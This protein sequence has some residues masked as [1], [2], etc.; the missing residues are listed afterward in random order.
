MVLAAMTWQDVANAPRDAVALIPTGA[1][2]QHGPFLPLMTDS[3]LVTAVAEEAERRLPGRVLLTPTLWLGASESHL[4]FA[5]TLSASFAGYGAALGAVVESLLAHGFHRY[6]VLNGHGGNTAPNAVALRELKARHPE[7][8]FGTAAYPEFGAAVIARTLAGPAKTMLHACEAETSL[9]LH[10]APDLV[11]M[12][13]VR[14]DGLYPD[15]PVVGMVHGF[16]EVS[17]EGP[18]GY[19]S[20]ATA[21]KGRA[22]FEACVEGLVKNLEW[23]ADGYVLNAKPRG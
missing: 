2:E 14:D 21:E 11:R 20:L 22:I 1:L 10:V 3:I 18:L 8:T 4:P 7:A 15:P 6:F 13:R 19:A 12:D 5:G 23:L 16:D 9:M 17:E